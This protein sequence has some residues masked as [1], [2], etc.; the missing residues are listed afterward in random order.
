MVLVIDGAERNTIFIGGQEFALVKPVDS[1]TVLWTG[2]QGSGTITLTDTVQNGW[3]NIDG[4]VLLYADSQ[5]SSG[6]TSVLWNDLGG[7]NNGGHPFKIPKEALLSATNKSWS[8]NIQTVRWAG[9]TG[10]VT[11]QAQVKVTPGNQSL[12]ISI[13][14]LYG[15]YSY[16]TQEPWE[17]HP[18]MTHEVWNNE[19]FTSN[20]KITRVVAYSN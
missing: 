15:R 19:T 17:G 18:G 14:D 20:V 10:N 7:W 9:K 6:Y 16:S 8:T 11:T 12:S 1:G 5:S 4:G 3:K 13:N 2:N